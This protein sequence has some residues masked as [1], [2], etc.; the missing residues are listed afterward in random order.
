MI[1]SRRKKLNRGKVR[2]AE[3]TQEGREQ[4][5]ETDVTKSSSQ[6]PY[7]TTFLIFES[8]SSAIV[9]LLVIL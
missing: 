6:R 4:E 2:R 9:Y 5:R 1:D 8:S 3:M 7:A